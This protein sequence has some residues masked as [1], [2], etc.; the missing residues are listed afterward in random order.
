MTALRWTVLALTAGALAGCGHRTQAA[1][2]QQAAVVPTVT[3]QVGTVTPTAVL[4][5]IVA[6][7]QDVGIVS[8]LAEPADV[9]SVKEGQIV[10]RGQVLAQLDTADLRAELAAD[11]ATVR[12][13]QAKQV[14]TYDQA[15][16]T[17]V[18]NSNTV[19]QARA[20]LLQAQ[21][22]L[23]N[24]T[25][26]LHRYAALVAQGYIPQQQYDT[27]AGLVRNDQ[28][29]VRAAQVTLQNDVQQVAANGTTSS[30]LQGSQVQA[31]AATTQMTQAQADQLRVQISKATIVSPIDGIVV[32]RNLNPGEY[33]GT[34]QIFTLQETDRVYA[35][36]D[37]SANAVAGV[38]PGNPVTVA[39]SA[40]GGKQFRGAIDG[41]LNPVNPGS[42]SF[43]IKALVPN[44]QGLLRP[45]MPVSSTVHLASVRGVR[46]PSTAFLDT[47]D[48][49]VQTV[50]GG[51]VHTA[52]VTAVA[53][54]ASYAIVAGLAVG[55]VVV[56][57]GQ[58]G[59]TDGQTVQSQPQVAQN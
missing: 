41:I 59:L 11:I 56:A 40:L 17:I 14:Q 25:T 28:Q 37:A 53:Q 31:A 33:P 34:R 52:R 7:L 24:D 38:Q 18:Q 23:A 10:R 55:A 8:T 15:S 1:P 22:T 45:G 43:I 47:T 46:I 5:G 57:N 54:D 2:A 4:P 50:G 29:A 20:A 27:Q 32:N 21:T 49:T 58:L 44:P 19:N 35:V 3:A 30:G 6:P 16:L 13:N 26:N 42:T 36:L 48:S 39:S 12:T 51:V 9:V